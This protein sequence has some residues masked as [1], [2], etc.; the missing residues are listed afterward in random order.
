MHQCNRTSHKRN[1]GSPA[2]AW[3]IGFRVLA[4]PAVM[5][6][7]N[8]LMSGLEAGSERPHYDDMDHKN[9]GDCG[10]SAAIARKIDA[11]CE[12]T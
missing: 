6:S 11:G 4:C 8:T 5:K 9:Q 1:R 12:K 7:A 3:Q 2:R 10:A